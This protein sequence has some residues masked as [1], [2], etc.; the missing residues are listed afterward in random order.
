M[1]LLFHSPLPLTSYKLKDVRLSPSSFSGRWECISRNNRSRFGFTSANSGKSGV[2]ALF[3]NPFD[4][5][6]LK[7]A[8]KE[9]V[10]FLGGVFAGVLRLDLEEEPL[11]E[12][13][14]RTVEAAGVNEDELDTEGS[15]TEAAPQQIEIE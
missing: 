8:V 13:V 10:A 1:S 9:P 11:K 5:P 7:E 2:R 3:F 15:T 4:D 14:T 6:I 12:W